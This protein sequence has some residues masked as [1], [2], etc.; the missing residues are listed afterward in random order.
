MSRWTS[1]IGAS[2]A[3]V[4]QA[5][6]VAS[7]GPFAAVG[8]GRRRAAA[9]RF[10]RLVLSCGSAPTSSAKS[11]GEITTICASGSVDL[12]LVRPCARSCAVVGHIQ[13]LVRRLVGA[14]GQHH[15]LRIDADEIVGEQLAVELVD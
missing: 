5:Q 8:F 12:D 1:R 15:D 13:A 4:R 2:R 3:G 11:G 7:D 6:P 10:R 14:E 9:G